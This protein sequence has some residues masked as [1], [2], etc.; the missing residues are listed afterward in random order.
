MRGSA[1]KYS[2]ALEKANSWWRPKTARAAWWFTAARLARY[3]GIDI[4]GFEKEPDFAI[5]N[6]ELTWFVF[7]ARPKPPDP[8]E[9]AGERKRVEA[10]KPLHDVRFQYR[11]TAVDEAMQSADL[12]PPHSQA[13]AAALVALLYLIRRAL[14]I[15][16]TPT[17]A[18]PK[19]TPEPKS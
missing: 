4:L 13:F 15:M 9:S 17:I 5:W 2:T 7:P 12:L 1:K 14:I 10:S 16:A 11:L 6:G 3:R 8:W 18:A 19:Q